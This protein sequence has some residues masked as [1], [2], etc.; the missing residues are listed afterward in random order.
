MSGYGWSWGQKKRMIL[1][2]AHRRHD[3]SD[4]GGRLLAAPLSGKTGGWDDRPKTIDRYHGFFGCFTR[5][6][7]ARLMVG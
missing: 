2:P 7:M 6:P 5:V 3:R 4:V 1:T